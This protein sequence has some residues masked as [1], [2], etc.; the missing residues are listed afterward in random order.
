MLW[1]IALAPLLL[2]GIP[3][4][5][6]AKILGLLALL[7]TA[8]IIY[9][10]LMLSMNRFIRRG[11]LCSWRFSHLHLR[12]FIRDGSHGLRLVMI[13]AA[14]FYYQG[15]LGLC[16]LM[17][18]L[19]ALARPDGLILVGLIWGAFIFEKLL[20]QAGLYRKDK[21]TWQ[22]AAKLFAFRSWLPDCGCCFA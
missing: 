21:S 16:A 3:A 20:S 1:V 6:A 10:W 4:P 9:R 18:A 7:G 19:T 11:A 13:A 12:G 14:W 5:L 22:D 17:S 15:K 2:V 8:W